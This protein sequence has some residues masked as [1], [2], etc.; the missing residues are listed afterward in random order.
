ML[1]ISYNMEKITYEK[2][3]NNPYNKFMEIQHTEPIVDHNLN[4]IND[5]KIQNIISEL[6]EID[7]TEFT[8]NIQNVMQLFTGSAGGED[9]E[10][11]ESGGS[12]GSGGSEGG[13]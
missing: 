4:I 7:F 2:Y 11:G 3:V 13:S 12:G 5:K 10:S 6:Q 8:Q 1:Y 9:E